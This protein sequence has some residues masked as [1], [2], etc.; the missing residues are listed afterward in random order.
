M[1]RVPIA[2]AKPGMVLAVPI[3]HPR[4]Q[5]T[6]LLSEGMSLDSRSIA[7]LAEIQLKDLWIRYPGVDFVGQYICPAVFDAHA[8]LTRKIAE[9]F[10]LVSLG[11]PT[12]LEYMA[13][14][15]S[16]SS[17]MDRL[18]ASPRAAVF[19]QEMVD[20]GAPILSHASTVSFIAVLMGL[21]LDDY[22][23]TERTRLV[24]HVA[25]DV[26]SLGV[27]AMLHD[28]GMLR[29]PPEVIEYW[30][31]TLDETHEPWRAH[32]QIG[33][34]LVK[35]AIGPSA[36][37]GVLHH[38]QKFNGGG[39]PARKKLGGGD[40][41]LSGSDIHVFARI[42]SV[43]DLFDRLRNPPGAPTDAAPVPVVRVL[44]Q[45]QEPP[46]SHWIDPMVFKALLAVV[47]AYLPGTMV[48]LSNGMQAV[49]VEW[50]PDD[51]C[52]PTV[53]TI[54]DPTVDFDKETR[55]S[56]RFVLRQMTGLTIVGAEGQDVSNDNF[57]PSVPGQF[58]LKLAG[59]A[60]FNSAVE[61][62]LER[63]G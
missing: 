25:R 20:R 57:Y 14:R 4:R 33:Y 22:L 55:A 24:S 38:H 45:L 19:V 7:R 10:E 32:V 29:L 3:Y 62:P 52:R 47:P 54:G 46:Y 61:L 59:K 6:V 56:D 37:A 40:E 60:L 63:A 42:I 1:L 18:I 36:A 15:H 50:F 35:D 11:T 53:Q 8:N 39:F 23:I 48:K 9:A 31:R 26:T 2:Y 44:R 58:D 30:N 34:E 41:R 5:D 43:A 49:V 21:K 28:V 27:G 16:I 51:P 13:Y 12:K 17:L